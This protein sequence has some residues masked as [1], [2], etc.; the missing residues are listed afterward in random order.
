MKKLISFLV[1]LLASVLSQAQTTTVTATVKYPDN[2]TFAN[3]T[4]LATFTPPTGTIDQN[5]YLLNG[6]AFPYYVS[7]TMNGSGTFTLVLT[8]DH[9]VNPQGGRWMFTV[10]S[11]V[12]VC[13]NSLQ[14]VFGASINLTTLINADVK[15]LLKDALQLPILFADSEVKTN[16]NGG[17]IY[18]NYVSG[19]ARCWNGSAW[20]NCTGAGGTTPG[21]PLNSVQYNCGSNFCGGNL[22]WDNTNN[23]LSFSNSQ[24]FLEGAGQVQI[25]ASLGASS[26]TINMLLQ[27]GSVSRLIASATADGLVREGIDQQ[28]NTAPGVDCSNGASGSHYIM[29][30][31]VFNSF[32]GAAFPSFCLDDTSVYVTKFT[33]NN[34]TAN[35]PIYANGSKLLASGSFVGNTTALATVNGALT[36]G[37]CVKSDTNHNLQDAGGPCASAGLTSVGLSTNSGFLTVGSSPLVAN[38]TITLNLTTGQTANQFLATPNG[39]TGTVGLRA[40]VSADI[41]TLNQNTTGNANTAT[42]LA[43]A[44]SL[45]ASGSAAQGIL[46]SGNATG[47]QVVT[48]NPSILLNTQGQLSPVTAVNGVATAAF[49]F[50]VPGNSLGTGRCLD[51]VVGWKHTTGTANTTYTFSYGATG[52]SGTN[53]ASTSNG[54]LGF[55]ICNNGA[56]N[57]QYAIMEGGNINGGVAPSFATSAIDSTVN[58]A[59]AFNFNIANNTDQITPEFWTVWLM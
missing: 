38:G 24:G 51:V 48:Q 28:T 3:G 22:L 50:T 26:P 43:G 9:R 13:T 32:L 39:A 15:P 12:T 46:A 58:Q 35:A 25:I 21:A 5:L 54:T 16:P 27:S 40:I 30:G 56:T 1:I 49:T 34:L 36:S 2:N 29:I 8:D 7:G 10:C 37:N 18:Y 41:P 47:C 42:A 31:D 11:V 55:K 17:S 4:V 53:S 57:S 14:D 19:V 33:V 59:I 20:S 44:P 52:F 23:I 45:C 6:A